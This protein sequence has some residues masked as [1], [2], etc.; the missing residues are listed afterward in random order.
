MRRYSAAQAKLEH[1]GGYDW[2]DRAASFVRGLGFT[3]A[4][5]ARPL[6]HVLGRRADSRVARQGAGVP[7]RPAAARRA[8]EPSRY[9]VARMAGEA[10]R[11]ARR[12]RHPRCAR[13][14]V[15][16]GGDDGGAGA[17]GRQVRLFPGR[18]AR[19]AA[20]A[21]R[22][23]DPPDEDRG[24]PGRADRTSR[25]V[26]RAL[27]LQG[28]QGAPGADEDQADQEAGGRARARARRQAPDARLRVSEAGAVGPRRPGRREPVAC[29]RARSSS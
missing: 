12:G 25:A 27:P 21:G 22:A 4:D 17:R 15:P 8:D 23:R 26:R 29:R 7:A 9:R 10:A 18:L 6:V 13:P 24:A 19:V 16:R 28:E 3:D 1:A 2:R 20:R 14:L 11:D 5:L